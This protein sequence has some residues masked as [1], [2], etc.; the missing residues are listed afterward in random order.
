MYSKIFAYAKECKINDLELYIHEKDEIEIGLFQGEIDTYKVASVKTI[1]ARGLY[2]GKMGYASSEKLTDGVEKYLVD[3]IVKN[4]E[5]I[6]STDAGIIYEGDKQYVS[7]QEFNNLAQFTMKD[8]IA[9]LKNLHQKLLKYDPRIIEVA[10]NSYSEIATRV[11]IINSK[12]VNLA[13]N[14]ALAYVYVSPV[15][16]EGE[17]S[18]DGSSI[19]FTT[20]FTKFNEDAIVKEA[21]DKALSR[22]GAKSVK[23]QDYKILLENRVVTSLIGAL[24]GNVYAENV[25]KGYSSLKGKLNT[26]IAAAKFSLVEDPHNQAYLGCSAFDD[27]GVATSYKRIIDKGV[28]KTYLY[29]L[30]TAL[31]DKVKSTGNGY[32]AGPNSLVATDTSTL[33]V[34]KGDKNFLELVTLVKDGLYITSLQG[35]HSGLDPISGNFS[36]QAEG[37][38]IENS[39][40]TRPV[41]LITV[42]GNLYELL[43]D[44][45][46]VGN[47]LNYAFNPSLLAPSII[48]RKLAVS[49]E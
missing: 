24:V 37:F 26:A 32:K 22:L 36:L 12:G 30:K 46:E 42:A 23:S 33:Y 41:N 39:K 13:K 17:I 28:L 8:K 21:C 43:K 15:A 19:V 3:A 48:V 35:L 7:F 11:Q 14:H 18:K 45:E 40:I 9:L 29:N 5:A 20:D 38:L 31:K 2:R 44:I 25:Q 34:E 10:D 47:D 16:K 27:E 49:G 1:A 4:A 6:T